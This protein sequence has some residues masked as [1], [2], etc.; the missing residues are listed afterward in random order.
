MPSP[1]ARRAQAAITGAVD[2]ITPLIAA[3]QPGDDPRA[4]AAAIMAKLTGDGWRQTS[5]S[6]SP[7][8]PPPRHPEPDPEPGAAP[9]LTPAAAVALA[10]TRAEQVAADRAAARD[11]D[12]RASRPAAPGGGCDR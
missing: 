12:R 1:E 2:A 6:S 9:P 3:C 11:R 5:A 10:K 8:V 7:W 4:A